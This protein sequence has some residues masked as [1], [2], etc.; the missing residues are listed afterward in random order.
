LSFAAAKKLELRTLGNRQEFLG[1]GVFWEYISRKQIF[2]SLHNFENSENMEEME[3]TKTCFEP[4]VG[5]LK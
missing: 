5:V 3:M 4:V 2:L 1:F